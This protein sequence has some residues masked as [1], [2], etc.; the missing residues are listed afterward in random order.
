M[1]F[2]FSLVLNL[3]NLNDEERI[4]HS[5]CGGEKAANKQPEITKLRKKPQGTRKS[6]EA[7]NAK[8]VH[9]FEPLTFGKFPIVFGQ[10]QREDEGDNPE[11]AQRRIEAHP[12]ILQTRCSV[13]DETEPELNTIDQEKQ[14]FHDL[15]SSRVAT[16]KAKFDLHTNCDGVDENDSPE[17]SVEVARRNDFMSPQAKLMPYLF[18]D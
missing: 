10:Q 7:Q 8:D 4:R 15:E 13:R 5:R 14:I 9:A 18:W 3:E 1:R 11:E 12:A 17:D 16:F 6:T 2:Q